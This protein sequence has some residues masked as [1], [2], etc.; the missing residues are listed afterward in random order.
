MGKQM[1]GT[2]GDF[3]IGVRKAVGTFGNCTTLRHGGYHTLVVYPLLAEAYRR[4]WLGEF[5]SSV[6][7]ATG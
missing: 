3:I 6:L 4:G 1:S 2:I 5:G 7:L